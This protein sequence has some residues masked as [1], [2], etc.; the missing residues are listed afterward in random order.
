VRAAGLR[1]APLRMTCGHDAVQVDGGLCVGNSAL[2]RH[3][4][5]SRRAAAWGLTCE[6][7]DC[8]SG[9]F[10][11]EMLNRCSCPGSWHWCCIQAGNQGLA[12]PP[13]NAHTRSHTHTH[14]HTHTSCFPPFAWATCAGG[15]KR[16][17]RAPSP[18][19]TSL[20]ALTSPARSHR[21]PMAS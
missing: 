8:W 16:G 19:I 14:T 21:P 7:P 2:D 11:L 17:V 18:G 9:A 1:T 15:K 5:I 3:L 20:P 13:L 4:P 12:P 6:G 10:L